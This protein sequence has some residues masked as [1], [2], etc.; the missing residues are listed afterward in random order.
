MSGSDADNHARDLA[1]LNRRRVSPQWAP[2]LTAMADELAAVSDQGA[3]QRFLRATGERM[4]RRAAL[5]KLETLEDLEARINA[6]LA[7][8]DWGWAQLT[9]AADHILIT[10]GACP[11]VLADD[12]RRSWPPLMA[13]V[14]AGAYGAWFAAQGSPG[15]VTSC[16]DPSASPLVF[17]HRV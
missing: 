10:H 12:D 11:N 2:F 16:R 17:E 3:V 5:P 8:M 14:L 15:G 9:A 4:A 7:D 6:V 13:E 1:Y